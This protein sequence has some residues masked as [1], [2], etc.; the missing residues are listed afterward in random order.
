MNPKPTALII[1]DEKGIQSFMETTLNANGY[2][3]QES[4]I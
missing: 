4:Q 3:M 2:R 1:E